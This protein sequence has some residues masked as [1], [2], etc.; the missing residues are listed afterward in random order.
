MLKNIFW[1]A[2]VAFLFIVTLDLQLTQ[3][4]IGNN[5][6]MEGNPLMALAIKKFGIRYAV[7]YARTVASVFV[8]FLLAFQDSKH[9]QYA[10]ISFVIFYYITMTD[11]LFYLNFMEMP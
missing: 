8:F 6:E 4:Y 9:F 1:F 5:W 2:F 10:F 3:N 11:W 7:W